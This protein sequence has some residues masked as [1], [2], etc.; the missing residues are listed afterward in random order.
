MK[1]YIMVLFIYLLE[2]LLFSKKGK[3]Y[4]IIYV[5]KTELIVKT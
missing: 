1:N 2:Y 5:M 3:L 4:Q